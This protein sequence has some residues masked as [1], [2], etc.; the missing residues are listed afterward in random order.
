LQKIQAPRA[1][2]ERLKRDYVLEE[3]GDVEVKGKG[4]MHTWYLV[5][6]R[7]QATQ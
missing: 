5:A 6:H 7:E 2:Y 1:V 4:T 3:R